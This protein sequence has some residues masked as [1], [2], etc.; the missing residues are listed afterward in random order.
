MQNTGTTNTTATSPSNPLATIP[1]IMGI[2]YAF[3]TF[4]LLIYALVFFHFKKKEDRNPS[5]LGKRTGCYAKMY[6]LIIRVFPLIIKLLHYIV[7]ILILVQIFVVI[8]SAP[9]KEPYSVDSFGIQKASPRWSLVV[10]AW[11]WVDSGN[12]DHD[13]YRISRLEKV[14]L[15]S[16]LSV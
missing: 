12:L 8:A 10:Y 14:A 5:E 15:R 6:G 16:L 3:I 11:F 7:L 1:L 2:F 9:C 4:L 13:S